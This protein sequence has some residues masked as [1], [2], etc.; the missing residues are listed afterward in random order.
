MSV[1]VALALLQSSLLVVGCAWIGARLGPPLG[2]ES[3]LWGVPSGAYSPSPVTG[4]VTMHAL[5][6]GVLAGM[7]TGA[8]GGVTACW[9][10]P[11]L[12]TYLR[13]TTPLVTRLF[14]GGLTEEVFMR[15]GFLASVG[16]LLSLL[17]RAL[18]GGTTSTGVRGAAVVPAILAILMTNGIFAVAHFP[19]LRA[20]KTSAPGRAA[21]VI[22]LISLPWGWLA[23]SFGL[24]SAMVAHMVFHGAVEAVG[25]RR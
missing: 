1:L 10:S 2:L 11:S 6:P 13:T 14:Y 9:L 3:R 23:W 17:S 20:A 8:L 7:L 4:A 16:A 18:F 19:T 12:I 5:W 21:A 22:F 25:P 15:W 24:E